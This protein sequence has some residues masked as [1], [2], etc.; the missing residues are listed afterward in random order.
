MHQ[1]LNSSQWKYQLFVL[2]YLTCLRRRQKNERITKMC[3]TVHYGPFT[4]A[5]KLSSTISGW[6]NFYFT[7]MWACYTIH[8]Q[9]TMH[10]QSIQ[11]FIMMSSNE[12]NKRWFVLVLFM[13]YIVIY[14]EC[15]RCVYIIIGIFRYISNTRLHTKTWHHE[16]FSLD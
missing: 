5:L 10:I 11:T 15:V 9:C 13:K 6:S 4:Q 1:M 3:A 7:K 2:Y 12:L 16:V 8:T 14:W